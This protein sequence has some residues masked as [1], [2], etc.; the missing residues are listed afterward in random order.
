[1]A[2]GAANH[3]MH[4]LEP[5]I[6]EWRRT[7]KAVPNIHPQ[8]LDELESHV[9]QTVAELVQSG[10]PE[11]EACRRAAAELGSPETM[12]AEF[13]KLRPAAW[14]PVKV[15][16]ALGVTLAVGLAWWLFGR[17]GARTSS[18]L[19]LGVHVFTVT[20]GYAAGLLLGL[21]GVCFVFQRCRGE[22]AP[23]RMAPLTRVSATFAATATGLTAL[24]IVLAMAWSKREW[25]QYW[26]WDAKE[27]GAL[28]ILLWMGGFLAAH[29]L[30]WVT[31]RGLLLASLAGSNVVALGWF[32]GL[33]PQRLQN[34]GGA[35]YVG[36]LLFLAVVGNLLVL[37][38]GLAPA[39]WLRWRKA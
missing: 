33:L 34:Y 24:G 13:L 35:G 16:T 28:C 27:I 10:V 8:T 12:A 20:L 37:L 19:L 4:N 39:G 15:V 36:I 3:T 25:G 26:N 18:D 31:P 14:L 23:R 11:A 29:S 17:S 5:F 38:L 21:L 32:G 6:I 1:M 22:L 2:A 7:M 30:R 9:R